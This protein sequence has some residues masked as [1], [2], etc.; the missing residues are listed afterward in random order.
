[1]RSAGLAW[2]VPWGCSTTRP[3]SA[4]IVQLAAVASATGFAHPGSPWTRRPLAR[5][6]APARR[7]EVEGRV[8]RRGRRRVVIGLSGRL[9][10]LGPTPAGNGSESP[11][12]LKG[13]I[14]LAAG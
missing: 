14:L 1:M 10:P 6:S 7:T 12:N 3:S 11:G 5:I 8:D 13:H 9:V 4:R 2:R